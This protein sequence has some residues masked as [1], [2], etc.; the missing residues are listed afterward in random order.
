[1][2]STVTPSTGDEED[3]RQP[4]EQPR[5]RSRSGGWKNELVRRRH[6]LAPVSTR[7]QSDDEDLTDE[8][9]YYKYRDKLY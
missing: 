7:F 9:L 4:A 3:A 2:T 5:R 1:M 8:E 6:W